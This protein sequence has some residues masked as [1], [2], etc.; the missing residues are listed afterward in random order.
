M[1]VVWDAKLQTWKILR[2]RDDKHDGNYR[3]VVFSI[4]HSIK[5]GVEADE[6]R[7]KQTI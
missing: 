4:I 1:E 5:D 6:V 2:F 3:D 7:F